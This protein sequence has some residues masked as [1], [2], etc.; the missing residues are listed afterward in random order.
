MNIVFT[1]QTAGLN[2]FYHLIQKMRQTLHIDRIGCYI[3][4]SMYYERFLKRHPEIETDYTIVKEWENVKLAL[5]VKP[6]L[7]TI[8]KYE[9]CYGNPTLWDAIICDRKIYQGKRVTERQ[10]YRP[11]FTHNEMLSMIQVSIEKLEA[12]LNR[13]EPDI[14]L[15]FDPITFGDYL[16]YLIAKSKKIPMLFFRTTK[17]EN[18]ISL[19]EGVSGCSP[20]ISNFYR[21]YEDRH[22]SDVWT[23]K[24][25]A[26]LQKIEDRDIRYEG[27]IPIPKRKKKYLFS[28]EYS[29]IKGLKSELE[30]RR[31]YKG[32][33]KNSDIF[34]PF[35]Y[36]NVISPLNSKKIDYSLSKH[37]VTLDHC[38]QWDFAFY[39]LQ[40]EPEI[41]LLIWGKS[42]MNQIEA[43]RN[44][45]RSLPVGMKL[46]VKEH[47]RAIGYRKL[48]YYE[49]ILEIPNV[50][51]IYPYE[52]VRNIIKRAKIVVAISTFVAFEAVIYKKPAIMLGG[53]RPFTILPNSM[54]RYVNSP[55]DLACEIDDLLKTYEFQEKSLIHYIAATMKG[56]VAI[57]LFTTLLKKKGR[58][59]DADADSFDEEIDKMSKYTI[60]RIR[61][62]VGS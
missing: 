52:E 44:I 47:P 50:S 25:I 49:K 48:G 43:I 14:I 23:E 55:N 59:G 29:L 35:L 21:E 28:S 4:Y 46:V 15:S 8:A 56:S 61:E 60:H 26:Y 31:K 42:Y 58:Y 30:Y 3:A 53:P 38:R 24:A 10:D 39:P 7:R 1:T 17:I 62:F 20:H 32:D 41:S 9:A 51:L 54:I 5:N 40:S 19:D 6:N 11:S 18:Y 57:D 12:L 27:M 16:L 33:H 2:V 45:A 22:Q 13:I 37:Y 36:K 34:I